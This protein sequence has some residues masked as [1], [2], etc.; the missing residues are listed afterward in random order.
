MRAHGDGLLMHEFAVERGHAQ[1]VLAG[2]NIAQAESAIEM[3]VRAMRFVG[4]PGVGQFDTVVEKGLGCF[5]VQFSLD[6][7]GKIVRLRPAGNAQKH[8]RHECG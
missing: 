1:H 2:G 3:D 5:A 6:G 4:T 8:N 7:C